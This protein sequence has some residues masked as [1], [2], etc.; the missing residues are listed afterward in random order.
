[1]DKAANGHRLTNA[2]GNALRDAIGSEISAELDDYSREMDALIDR[3]GQMMEW[4]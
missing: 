2:E 3:I 1:V 4:D